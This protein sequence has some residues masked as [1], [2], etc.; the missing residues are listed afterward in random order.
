MTDETRAYIR[1]PQRVALVL[2]L[3][4]N[5]FTHEALAT[6][7]GRS[8]QAVKEF[9]ARNAAEIQEARNAI[10]EDVAE[11]LRGVPVAIRANRIKWLDEYRLDCEAALQD[12]GL[13]PGQR[14]RYINT[15]AKLLHQIAEQLGDLPSRS[16]VQLEISKASLADF[17]EIIL[18]DDGQFHAVAGT[19]HTKP[20]G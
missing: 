9:S 10:N 8:L 18:D 6:K 14:I 16:Q 3:A 17:D 7:Y 20:H 12:P 19:Q 5:E 4:S 2:D 15:V 11:G 13:T 1:G